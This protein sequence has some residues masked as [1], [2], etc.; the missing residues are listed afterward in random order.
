MYD[1]IEYRHCEVIDTK[2]SAQGKSNPNPGVQCIHCDSRFSGG[3]S[4]IR[5]HILRI[6]NRG[7]GACTSDTQAAEDA[8]DFFQ[9]VEDSLEATREK[10]RKRNEL[11]ELT[12]ASGCKGSTDTLVQISI[13]TAFAPAAKAMTDA[14]VARFVYAE[15]VPFAKVQSPYFQ[16]ML[17]AVGQF[18]RGYKPPSMKKL[19]TSMLDEEVENVKQQLKV[20]AQLRPHVALLHYACHSPGSVCP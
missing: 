4:R 18:G 20:N 15:G 14:A 6:S 12:D 8:R 10:K 16:D 2:L 5:G 17:T 3:P 13:E 11:D 19:R 9:K 7:G 1:A